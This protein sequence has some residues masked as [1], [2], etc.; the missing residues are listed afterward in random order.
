[1]ARNDGLATSGA[2]LLT[3]VVSSVQDLGATVAEVRAGIAVIR[4]GLLFRRGK[5]TSSERVELS[6][7]L[8]RRGS[9]TW[10]LKGNVLRYDDI[11]S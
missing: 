1:M 9:K 7:T 4:L 11:E 6:S 5:A 8:R 2:G 10:F 3:R